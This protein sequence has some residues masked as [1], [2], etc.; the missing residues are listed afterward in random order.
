M[1]LGVVIPVFR[2]GEE[3]ERVVDALAD[4]ARVR[5][6]RCRV[7]LVED[8]G[9]DAARVREIAARTPG[10]TG[11]LLERNVGQQMATYLGLSF[12][13][14]CDMVVTMDDDGQHPVALLDRMLERLRNGAELCY[15]VPI[16]E[17]VPAFRRMGG[18]LRDILF[19]MCT[20]QPRGVKVS[21]YRV[22]AGALA[23]RI[24][25][26]PDGYI[27]LSAA[28]FLH[29]PRTECLYYP[30]G[31]SNASTYTF[32]KLAR[33]YAGLL[34]HYTPLRALLPVRRQGACPMRALPGKGFL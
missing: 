10:V 33:L 32:I 13:A 8:F 3:L 20:Q 4:F 15:A 2:A 16:R 34:I 22:M 17:N 5:G 24:Q 19:S 27:Y 1:T 26:A 29:K 30:A 7:V 21:A 28:A 6:I 9:G 18:V 23:R 31:P 14:D 25:P 12:V 11:V